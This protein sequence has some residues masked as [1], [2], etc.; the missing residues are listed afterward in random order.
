MVHRQKHLEGL[1]RFIGLY[2]INEWT[3]ERTVLRRVRMER[4][5]AFRP[6]R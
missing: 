6:L 2:L 1:R 5:D 4:I 3:F